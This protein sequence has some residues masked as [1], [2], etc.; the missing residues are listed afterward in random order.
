MLDQ[1]VF[2]FFFFFFIVFSSFASNKLD[3]ILFVMN[4]MFYF[5]TLAFS[6]QM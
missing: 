1:T 6:R 4:I 2:F 3:R 5:F